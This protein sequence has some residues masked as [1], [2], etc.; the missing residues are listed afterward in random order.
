[1]S[2]AERDRMLINHKVDFDMLQPCHLVLQL[3]PLQ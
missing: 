2:G 1:M 3:A